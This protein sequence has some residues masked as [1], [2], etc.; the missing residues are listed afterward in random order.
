MIDPEVLHWP[1]GEQVVLWHPVTGRHVLLHRETLAALEADPDAPRLA[2]LRRRLSDEHMLG[3]AD[4]DALVVARSKMVLLLPGGLWGP[5][6][7]VRT[8]GGH[9]Y[10]EIP[11]TDEE[12]ATWRAVNDH[13]TGAEVAE[14]AGVSREAV[15]A[16]LRR[17][18]APDV[19][20]VQLRAS[21]PR[22]G[23]PSLRRVLAPA[24]PDADRSPDQH[25][26]SGETTLAAYHLHDVT[27]G[28]THF[29]D[30]ETTVAHALALPH[31][32][33]GGQPYGGRLREVLAAR[34]LGG[35]TVEVG[36]GTGEMAAAFGVRPYL[37]VDLSPEL[38]RTQVRNAPG[39]A[40]VLGDATRLPIRDGSVDLV[41]SNEVMA[42]LVA[43]PVATPGVRERLARY[44]VPEGDALYNLGA[45]RLLEEVARVLRP[46]GG[47]FLSEFGSLDEAPEEATHLDHPEVSIHFGHLLRVAEGLG[48]HAEVVP[49]PDLLGLDR[50]ARH[51]A[52]HSHAALRARAHA[53]GWHLPA[54]AWTPEQL[55]A[56]LPWPVEGLDWVPVSEPGPGPVI[57]RFLALLVR[58]PA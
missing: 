53:E 24:R 36:C 35:L 18:T 22:A 49:L 54:R 6:P 40:G 10:R 50:T 34:G 5:V 27:D 15:R 21:P 30:R 19:Q 32:A 4:P 25:G 9:A 58:R 8:P 56:V 41:L 1:L 7:A 28:A 43:A 48:L 2:A 31:P 51:L 57:D 3:P 37:R 47:A 16:F 12:T 44:G 39:T 20:A 55:A 52:R 26:P 13:R 11:L 46:G 33:L 45:W 42:D 14:R 17:L 29:D 23:D 38:L